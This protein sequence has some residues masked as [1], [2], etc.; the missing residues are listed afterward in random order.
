MCSSASCAPSWRKRRSDRPWVRAEGRAGL[1][2]AFFCTESEILRPLFPGHPL[3][4]PVWSE[5]RYTADCYIMS[6]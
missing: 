3:P 4:E 1:F 5:M 2:A 6:K